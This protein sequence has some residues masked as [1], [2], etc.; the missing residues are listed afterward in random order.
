M[1]GDTSMRMNHQCCLILG[2]A[3]VCTG[4]IGRHTKITESH[5]CTILNNRSSN[6]M[7]PVAVSTSP[8]TV[9]G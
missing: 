4:N 9:P 6:H 7:A 2:E 8:D 5:T 3:E 1:R